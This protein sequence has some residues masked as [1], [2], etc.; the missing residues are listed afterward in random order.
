MPALAEAGSIRLSGENDLVNFAFRVKKVTAEIAR[1]QS[2][3]HRIAHNGTAPLGI[4][5]QGRTH[6]DISGYYASHA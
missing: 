3:R 4:Y 2:T 6:D 1:L 5:R